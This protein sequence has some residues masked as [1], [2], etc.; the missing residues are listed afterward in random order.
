MIGNTAKDGS[1]SAYWCL[2]DNDGRLRICGPAQDPTT[3]SINKATSGD[4]TAIAA[5]G[6]G[7]K[8]RI[9]SLVLQNTD[10]AALTIILKDGATAING[11]GWVLP[12]NGFSPNIAHPLAPIDLGNNNAFVINLSANKQLS[13]YVTYTIE[14]V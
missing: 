12:S 2:Q 13:G 7:N 6:V 3:A 11:A 14:P 1:G 4:Q 8:I 10:A 5:P 9:L